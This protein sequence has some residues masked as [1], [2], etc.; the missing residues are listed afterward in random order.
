MK[1]YKIN[2]KKYNNRS[3]KDNKIINDKYNNEPKEILNLIQKYPRNYTDILKQATNKND[4]KLVNV[5]VAALLD[6]KIVKR[7]KET[8]QIISENGFEVLVI[9][10]ANNHADLLHKL[11][12]ALPKTQRSSKT[13]ILSLIASA[14]VSG[15]SNIVASLVKKLLPT[16]Q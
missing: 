3:S 6:Q 5:L 8:Q 2:I 15:H 9:L 10:A 12:N 13:L 1:K 7:K 11:L 14:A 4:S 16:L